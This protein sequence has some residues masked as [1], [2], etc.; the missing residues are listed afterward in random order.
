MG[1][2]TMNK[3][4]PFEC[5]NP[6]DGIFSDDAFQSLCQDVTEPGVDVDCSIWFAD[7]MADVCPECVPNCVYYEWIDSNSVAGDGYGGINSWSCIHRMTCALCKKDWQKTL[8]P[9]KLEDS[10]VELDDIDDLQECIQLKL[11]PFLNVT[12]LKVTTSNVA[13]ENIS[14]ETCVESLAA[15]MAVDPLFEHEFGCVVEYVDDIS[16]ILPMYE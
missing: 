15:I 16:E 7:Y 6:D 10:G 13:Q 12:N 2:S 8:D 11:Q 3:L 9:I 4:S 1:A 14:N 5:I